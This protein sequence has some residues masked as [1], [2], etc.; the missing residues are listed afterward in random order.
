[1]LVM[2][3][4]ISGSGRKEYIE[5][6]VKFAR[7]KKKSIQVFNIGE[8]ILEHAQRMDMNITKENILNTSPYTLKALRSAVFERIVG[9]VKRHKNVIIET[10]GTFYWKKIFSNAYDWEY[11]QKLKPDMFVTII[12]NVPEMAARHRASDQWSEA[13]LSE[14]EILLWQNLEVNTAKGWSD[15]FDSPSFA[16]SERQP[17]STL[18]KLM[19]H[20][21]ME[22]VYAS[23]PMTHL[24]RPADKKRIVE[25]VR[26]LNDY[27]VVFDPSTIELGPVT[28]EVDAF[29]CV[30]RDLYWLVDQSKKVIALFPEVVMSTGVINE[31]RE[32][33]ETN[34]EVWLIYPKKGISP[35]TSY[36]SHRMFYS[37]KEFWDF[38]RK[39]GYRK[40]KGAN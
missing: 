5:K 21:G 36:F 35:F 16:C 34:R 15:L 20:P 1:M 2:V 40:V 18:Y 19:F 3:T 6:V 29:Q 17:P 38:I 14:D 8:M 4:G 32:A 10:H 13:E 22:P 23:F 9:E 26:K 25:F 28:S 31:L 7:R 39:K 37:E 12:G 24:K 27:F 11:L 30:N 33:F